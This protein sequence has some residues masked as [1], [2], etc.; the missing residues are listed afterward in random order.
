MWYNVMFA[1]K[2]SDKSAA[3]KALE[4]TK[5]EIAKHAV[6]EEYSGQLNTLTDS[7]SICENALI[8]NDEIG[9]RYEFFETVLTDILKA[10]ANEGITFEG[11]ASWDSSYDWEQ[12]K[13]A[14]N[15]YQMYITTHFHSVDNEP[16]CPECEEPFLYDEMEDCYICEC[17]EKMS[18]RTL[19]SVNLPTR[20]SM[21]LN[22]NKCHYNDQYNN[23]SCYNIVT[24]LR[25]IRPQPK[26]KQR[27]AT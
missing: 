3:T 4:I 20:K 25:E 14:F 21:I 13:Y 18:V 6:S 7:L 1:V 17:G 9:F 5:R 16:I 8:S 19:P 23:R 10:I 15:G 24:R 2:M 11:S 26:Q 27:V 12:F 22:S